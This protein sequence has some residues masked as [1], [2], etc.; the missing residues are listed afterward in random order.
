MIDY[1]GKC[2]WAI[3]RTPFATV[4]SSLNTDCYSAGAAADF[5]L[6]PFKVSHYAF[7]SVLKLKELLS[8]E[9]VCK[10]WSPILYDRRSEMIGHSVQ[11][12]Q[13]VLK[14]NAWLSSRDRVA[15]V[16]TKT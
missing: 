15:L 3:D 6:K 7:R 13:Y 16:R 5:N 2:T 11:Y 10:E 1:Q 8:L 12:Q 14:K 9:N 4:Q